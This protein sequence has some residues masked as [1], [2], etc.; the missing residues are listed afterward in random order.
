MRLA[1]TRALLVSMLTD[2]AEKDQKFGIKVMESVPL[3]S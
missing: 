2:I 1:A 3:N